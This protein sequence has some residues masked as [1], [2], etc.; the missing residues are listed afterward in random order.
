MMLD[1]PIK[2]ELYNLKEATEEGDWKKST[3]GKVSD[4]ALARA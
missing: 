4:E 2:A 1:G 3:K